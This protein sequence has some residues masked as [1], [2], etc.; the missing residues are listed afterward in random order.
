[1]IK[2]DLM[3]RGLDPA[4]QLSAVST[5]LHVEYNSIPAAQDWK[6][7]RRPPQNTVLIGRLTLNPK[8]RAAAGGPRAPAA[9]KQEGGRGGC[10]AE[11]DR[12]DDGG[13]RHQAHPA[14]LEGPRPVQVELKSF[15]K[16]FS[17][18]PSLGAGPARCRSGIESPNN[19]VSIVTWSSA[20]RWPGG[21]RT[22]SGRGKESLKHTPVQ[23]RPRSPCFQIPPATILIIRTLS[24]ASCWPRRTR[25][26]LGAKAWIMCARPCVDSCDA[27]PY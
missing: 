2:H 21:T 7:S 14:G 12:V 19:V 15:L 8:A 16:S 1:M 4:E 5:G 20:S 9:R 13:G 6:Q 24:S 3:L 27:V 18:H 17:T 25:T 11:G 23:A 10:A 26:C 22:C